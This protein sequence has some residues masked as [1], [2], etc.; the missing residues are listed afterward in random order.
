MTVNRGESWT[1]FFKLIFQVSQT[2]T[3]PNR[4]FERAL[5]AP[6]KHYFTKKKKITLRCRGKVS[7]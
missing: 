7:F 3:F 2:Q 5:L 4:D 6:K 1:H